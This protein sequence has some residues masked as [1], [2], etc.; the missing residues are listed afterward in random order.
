M[1]FLATMLLVCA[2]SPASAQWLR[3]PTPGI[4]RTADGKPNL[5]APAP[6]T[7]DGHPDLS[8]LRASS[9]AGDL[10]S[11]ADKV[12]PWLQALMKQRA[13]NFGKDSPSYQCL[14]SG[15]AS[16]VGAGGMKRI[17]Q[18]PALMVI[19]S[20]DLTYPQIFTDGR[21]LESEPNPSW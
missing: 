13:E 6:R 7:H 1:K 20:E 8:G 12:Q 16:S 4:P 21:A 17:V 10:F 3:F 11:A 18:T 15:P 9:G 14:P 19:L 5:A 2:T